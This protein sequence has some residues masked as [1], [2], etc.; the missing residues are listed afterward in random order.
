VSATA[1][2]NAPFLCPKSELLISSVDRAGQLTLTK[3]APARGLCARIHRASTFF[4]VPLSPRRSTTQSEA[5]ARPAVCKNDRND[6]LAV[7][8]KLST[9]ASSSRSSSSETLRLRALASTTRRVAC[10]TCSGVKGFG[11]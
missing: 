1:P 8:K 7:S 6:G 10:R 3:G 9:S 2:V 4:P 11:R 5:A